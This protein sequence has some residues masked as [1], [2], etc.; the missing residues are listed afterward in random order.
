MRIKTYISALFFILFLTFS[1]RSSK[2]TIS[3][4]DLKYPKRE[5]RGAWLSTAWQS[6]YKSMNSEQMKAYF[7]QSLDQLHKVGINAVI[8]QVRP[9]AD[10]FYKSKYEPWSA[11]LSGTQGVVPEDGFDPLA[12]LVAEC[13]A[14]GMELHAWLNPYRVTTSAND[15]LVKDHIYYQKPDLFV[16]YGDKIYFDPGKKESRNFICKVVKDIVL[17][18]D[19]D[20]IHM[21]DY[22]YPYPIVG[23]DFPDDA[24]FQETRQQ[25][26]FDISSKND[27]RRN[28]VNLLIKEI[29]ETLMGT[30]PWVRFGISPFGIY[31]NKKSTPDGSGSNTNGLQ[32]YDDLYADVKLWVK[33]GWVDY[34][35]PQLYWEIGHKSA[36]YNI[37]VE[38]WAANNFDKPLYIGQD[39][40]RTMNAEVAEGR[41]EL[42]AK[43]MDARKYK[44]IGGSC[45]W[46]AY[47]LL[48]NY[49]NISTDLEDD[50][51]RYPALIPAYTHM[52]D[53]QPKKISKLKEEYTPDK[54]LLTWE[55][56]HVEND[57]VT[58]FY[59]VVYRFQHGEKT[60]L[61]KAQNIVA[62]TSD[63]HYELPY[64]D[65][66]TSYKYV[67]T[68]VDRFYNES[69]PREK[70]VKL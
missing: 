52:S 53:K 62:I 6:R 59:Y 64:I 60:D 55:S 42:S 54:H 58:A 18:Y 44:S 25:F 43:I 20:A 13:H 24:S 39:V 28:N 16:T 30:K 10:A 12:F 15:Q 67:V 1:C 68:A 51:Y 32:N 2:Q 7:T 34:N 26:G 38:W 45:F 61:N 35:L 47:S 65:A 57:P 40:V 5:F 4:S 49:K 46:S 17:N 50:F 27:W 11:H 9:Q 48:E 23:V 63:T 21:D 41:S 8:F 3:Y 14:R 56:N 69:K 33:E 22:F 19:V 31:R 70:K 66:K 36:D 37:L 29:K